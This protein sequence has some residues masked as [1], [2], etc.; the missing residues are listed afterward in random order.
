MRLLLLL[1]KRLVVYTIM[2]LLSLLAFEQFLTN[3]FQLIAKFSD[4]TI[5][6][7]VWTFYVKCHRL[8]YPD[9]SSGPRMWAWILIPLLTAYGVI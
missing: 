5:F 1:T 3:L 6:E 7:E 2:S 9:S 4:E 8:S